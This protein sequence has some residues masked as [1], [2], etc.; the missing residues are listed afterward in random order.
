M[1]FDGFSFLRHHPVGINQEL[2][3]LGATALVDI[4]THF[5]HY[6]L[7]IDQ[8]MQA[9]GNEQFS[10]ALVWIR[11]GGRLGSAILRERGLPKE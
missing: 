9:M 4:R 2:V 10:V 7:G 6:G 5:D 1:A 8:S 3:L 11:R